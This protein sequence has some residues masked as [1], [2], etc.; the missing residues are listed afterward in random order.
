MTALTPLEVSVLD[1]TR[2]R[3]Q[4]S[5]RTSRSASLSATSSS[6]VTRPTKS[7]SRSGA[8]ADVCSIRICVCSSLTVIVG[9]KMRG[10]ADRDVGATRTV[11]SIRSSDCTMTACRLPCCSLP[12][13]PRGARS[14][15]MAPRTKLI[16]LG[17]HLAAL[18]A[19][20][21]VVGEAARRRRVLGEW[22]L[23]RST[24]SSARARS[25]RSSVRKLTTGYDNHTTRCKT[26]QPRAMGRAQAAGPGT[27][28][29]ECS[30]GGDH[31]VSGARGSAGRTEKRAG[32]A[33]G[34]SQDAA[35][36]PPWN[37]HIGAGRW[38]ARAFRTRGR[39]T[40]SGYSLSVKR[41]SRTR[42]GAVR[43][44]RQS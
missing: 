30:N 32:N 44:R 8:T 33:P 37:R 11:D 2:H 7:P 41:A 25:E 24:R 10:G 20:G 21:F 29:A 36:D 38:D 34:I 26:F 16:H 13:A 31:A 27:R 9:R 4:S 12:T 1:P 22:P 35:L 39:R 19:V 42:S 15:W 5:S 17:E 14:R 18:G 28:I 6:Y 43:D 23:T 3:C 40:V